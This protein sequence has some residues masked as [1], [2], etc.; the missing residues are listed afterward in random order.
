MKQKLNGE[1]TILETIEGEILQPKTPIRELKRLGV[2][3][4]RILGPH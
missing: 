3:I 2:L 1:P 4:R